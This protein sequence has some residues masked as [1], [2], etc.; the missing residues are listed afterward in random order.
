MYLGEPERSERLVIGLHGEK[1]GWQFP[2]GVGMT[3][4]MPRKMMFLLV[5]LQRC[6]Y[7]EIIMRNNKRSKVAH[8]FNQ[9]TLP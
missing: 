7:L 4:S 1:R 5:I 3:S 9:N 8:E 6:Q 2:F